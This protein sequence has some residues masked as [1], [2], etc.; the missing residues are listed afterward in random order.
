MGLLLFVEPEGIDGF[1]CH[2]T[3]DHDFCVDLRRQCWCRHWFVVQW[4]TRELDYPYKLV[5]GLRA[6]V[7]RSF[8]F[9]RWGS[10]QLERDGDDEQWRYTMLIRLDPAGYGLS[11]RDIERIGDPDPKVAKLSF[12]RKECTEWRFRCCAQ[13]LRE[14]VPGWILS[15]LGGGS[16]IPFGKEVVRW[17]LESAMK[18][19]GVL[20]F[21]RD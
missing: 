7:K 1:E 2:C 4:V 12:D 11:D 8:K 21:P 14:E 5:K 3:C 18:N 17:E 20:S 16:R 13:R 10:Y 15:I 9:E 19:A 6:L